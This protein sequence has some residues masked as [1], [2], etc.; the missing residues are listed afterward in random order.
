MRGRLLVASI[1]KLEAYYR[2]S[3]NAEE[4]PEID[5]KIDGG[6]NIQIHETETS[7][8]LKLL[9]RFL[10]SAVVIVFLLALSFGVEWFATVTHQKQEPW[11]MSLLKWT[12]SFTLWGVLVVAGFEFLRIC[13]EVS[14]SFLGDAIKAIIKLKEGDS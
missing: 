1:I 11:V 6:K 13:L 2:M 10:R 8:F 14:V 9:G 7:Y 5:E 12:N 4:L 3:D